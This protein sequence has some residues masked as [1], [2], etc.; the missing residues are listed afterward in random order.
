MWKGQTMMLAAI[1]D[2]I[3]Y[4]VLA[5][6]VLFALGLVVLLITRVAQAKKRGEDGPIEGA[7]KAGHQAGWE[8]GQKLG[9]WL[10][11]KLGKG[12]KKNND[13]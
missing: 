10:R 12:P 3:A 6:I 4:I 1:G 8:L 7:Y 13:A 9:T 2:A 11:E 5:L